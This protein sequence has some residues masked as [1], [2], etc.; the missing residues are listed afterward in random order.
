MSNERVYVVSREAVVEARCM[1]EV[2]G[3]ASILLVGRGLMLP[4]TLF[5]KRNVYAIAEEVD[6]LGLTG[7]LSKN[8]KALPAGEIVDLLM[9]R[10]VLNFS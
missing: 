10:Q 4:A 6:E 7:K 3:D 9:D 8:I 1:L 5:A 2:E